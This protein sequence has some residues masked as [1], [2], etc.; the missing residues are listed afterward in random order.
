M[1]PEITLGDVIDNK[2]NSPVVPTIEVSTADTTASED[3]SLEITHT[4]AAQVMMI[5]TE[6]TIADISASSG[7]NHKSPAINFYLLLFLISE[8]LQKS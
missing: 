5:S 1:P 4:E 2:M 6:V 3:T 7:N 8:F